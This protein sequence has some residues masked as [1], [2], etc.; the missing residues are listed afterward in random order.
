MKRFSLVLMALAF[1]IFALTSCGKDP[2]DETKGNEGESRIVSVSFELSVDN[3]SKTDF[4]NF[5]TNNNTQAATIDWNKT[6]Y[7]TVYLAVPDIKIIRPFYYYKECARMIPLRAKCNGSS[8]LLFEGSIDSDDLMEGHSYILYYFGNENGG[9]TTEIRDD[10]GNLMGMTLNLNNQNGTRSALGDMHF[11]SLQVVVSVSYIDEETAE[12]ESF[13][14]TA[15]SNPYFTSGVAISLLDLEGV[16]KLEGKAVSNTAVEVKFDRT[17]NKY[18]ISY[19]N[20]DGNSGITLN[21][22][23]KESFIV[24]T[25]NEQSGV[26]LECSKGKYIF[27]NGVETNNV[28]YNYNTKTQRIEPLKWI[29]E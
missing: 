3:N 10:A 24:M 5:L 21:N 29:T 16:N 19:T 7:E 18:L 12:I 20:V 25:P 27:E 26:T 11:A 15:D 23:T 1:A 22:T 2:I 4:S 17:S 9:K 6:G 28:Y 8:K 13:T 14:L